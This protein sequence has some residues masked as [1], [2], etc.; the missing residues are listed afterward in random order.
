MTAR[1][2]NTDLLDHA[3]SDA[4]RSL[5]PAADVDQQV[6]AGPRAQDTLTRILATG[7]VGPA[8]P[9]PVRTG[10]AR[11][12]RRWVLGAVALVVASA[13]VVLPGLGHGEKAFASWSAI[14]KAVAPA[15]VSAIGRQCKTYWDGPAGPWPA[16][17]AKMVEDSQPVIVERRGLWTFVLL[18]GRGGFKA[19]CLHPTVPGSVSGSNG[20]GSAQTHDTAFAAYDTAVTDGASQYGDGDGSY[21]EMTGRVGAKVSSVV[22]NT[23]E[24]GP[25]MATV[26]DGYFAAWWP[27]P[28]MA[29]AEIHSH[30]TSITLVLKDGT[31]KANIPMAQLDP[32]RN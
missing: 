5:D 7:S 4:L 3:T 22:I 25:V 1:L 24:Q 6:V 32:A 11:P 8:T 27:G 18:A 29:Q 15:E 12:R 14:A 23:A 21:F 17:D 31:T 16:S 26:H 28:G 30:E 13:L 20:G 10:W 19:T 9:P 2:H